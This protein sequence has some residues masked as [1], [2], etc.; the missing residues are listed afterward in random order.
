MVTIVG[1]SGRAFFPALP[2]APSAMLVAAGLLTTAGV[3]AA[4]G[5]GGTAA[6]RA[7]ESPAAAM[8]IIV[9]SPVVS[10]GGTIPRRFTCDGGDVSLPLVFSGVPSGTAGLALLVEDP[11]APDRTFVHWAAWGIDPGQATLGEG[12]LPPGAV[13]G[14]NDFGKQGYGGP[15]PPHG[16]NHRYVI[17]VFAVSAP[18]NLRAGASGA[19]LRA[20]A[21]SK[22]LAWGRLTTRYAR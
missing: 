19:D 1:R 12:Q 16:Q 5:G 9:S 4:C 22:L 17:T 18:V 15:C 8:S 2:L 7:V 10:E 3:L 13:Q 21:N 11:D 14:R 20:A 6:G